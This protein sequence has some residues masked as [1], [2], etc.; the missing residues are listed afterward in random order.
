MSQDKRGLRG[1]ERIPKSSMA[2]DRLSG[3]FDSPLVP[4]D[5]LRARGLAKEDRKK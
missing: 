3:S 5:K 4:F 1:F 2:E